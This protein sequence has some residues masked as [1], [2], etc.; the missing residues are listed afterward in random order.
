MKE[1]IRGVGLSFDIEGKISLKEGGSLFGPPPSLLV[2]SSELM[3]G[4]PLVIRQCIYKSP[5]LKTFWPAR[6]KGKGFPI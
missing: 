6:V 2:L 5:T 1:C 3:F 4:H